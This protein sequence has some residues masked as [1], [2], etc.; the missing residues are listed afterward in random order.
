LLVLSFAGGVAAAAA[1]WLLL[2]RQA[3]ERT[4]SELMDVVM[5]NKEPIGGA[6]SLIDHEGRRRSDADF[7]GKLLLVYFGFTFCSDVCPVDL[8]SIATTLDRLG[9]AGERVQPLF[10]TVDPEKDTPSQLK[11]Y[12]ALFHPRL[13]GLTGSAPEIKQAA[14]AYKVYYAKT[15]D[16]K[17]TGTR[18]ALAKRDGY[19]IDHTG[20]VFL[21]GKGGEYLGY[22]PPGTPADRMIEAIRP[23]V[24]ALSHDGRRAPEDSGIH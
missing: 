16:T 17:P 15:K 20:F 10:I 1:G 14:S 7:R 19:E 11:A 13:I 12:V 3:T 23:L 21:V 22:L 24:S 9:P 5:W 18:T 2:P 4:A 8:Q 6:F